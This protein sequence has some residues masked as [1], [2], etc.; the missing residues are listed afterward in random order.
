MQVAQAHVAVPGQ[1]A[2]QGIAVLPLPH[3]IG[4]H[5]HEV[6]RGSAPGLGSPATTNARLSA[7]LAK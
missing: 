7:T 3:T 4:G 5:W 6:A 2:W 1:L